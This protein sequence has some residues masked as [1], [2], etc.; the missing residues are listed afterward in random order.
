MLNYLL[1][2]KATHDVTAYHFNKPDMTR[3]AQ[4]RVCLCVYCSKFSQ[5]SRGEQRMGE[6]VILHEAPHF[7]DQS[8][9]K[10][11]LLNSTWLDSITSGDRRRD[12]FKW[13]PWSEENVCATSMTC[14]TGYEIKNTLFVSLLECLTQHRSLKSLCESDVMK[15]W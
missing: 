7:N 6:N 14:A 2:L 15:C 11:S 10:G 9:F 13:S 3:F 1:C 12:A 8:Q 4:A 5:A